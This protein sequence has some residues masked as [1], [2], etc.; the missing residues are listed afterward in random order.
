MLLRATEIRIDAHGGPDRLTPVEID[1]ARPGAGQ[2]L[3]RQ[4]AVG[5]N[6]IDVYHRRGIFPIPALPGAVGVEGVGIVEAAGPGVSLRPGDRVG[7][8]GPPVGSYASA[9]VMDAARLVRLPDG[10]PDAEAAALMLKGMTAHMLF[11][12]VRPLRPG[13][14]V[15]VHAAAGGLGLLLTQ[16]ARAAGARVIGT[17]GSEAKAETARAAGCEATILY[18]TQDFVAETLRLTGGEGV[19]VVCEGLGGPV[20]ERS[21]DCL[22][23]FGTA[24]NLGQAGEKLA[25]IDLARLGPQRSLCV[26]VPGVFA[27][28]RTVPDLQAAADEMFAMVARGH[29]RPV[30]GLRAPLR[31]AGAVHRRL[32]AGET[33]GATVLLP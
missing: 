3:L 15:L 1:L 22:K 14:A 27:H 28:L 16:W 31:E 26:S 13:D 32:E 24:I 19:D 21:L 5:V 20:L 25:A 2:V 17:V 23:P 9:R 29:L 18:R 6:F 30:I 11:T 12:R 7:Y 10:I 4:T 8:A 33:S